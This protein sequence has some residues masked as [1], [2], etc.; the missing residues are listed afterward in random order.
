MQGLSGFGPVLWPAN[1]QVAGKNLVNQQ[2]FLR[3]P[4]G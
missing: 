2:L 3:R 1:E 4:D